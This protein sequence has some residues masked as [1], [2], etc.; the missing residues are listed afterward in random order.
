MKKFLDYVKFNN[1]ELVCQALD[2]SIKYLYQYDYF[3]QTPIHWAAKLG[4]EKMLELFLRYTELIFIIK[5]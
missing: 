2:K 1:Y 4:Y 3:R 5:I